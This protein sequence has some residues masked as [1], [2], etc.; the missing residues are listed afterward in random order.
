MDL[1]YSTTLAN[2]KTCDVAPSVGDLGITNSRLIAPGDAAR[3]V[4]IARMSRRDAHGMPPLGSA[5]VDAE[6]AALLTSWVN[7]LTNCN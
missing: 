2:T 3:S 1:R 5:Q 7:S 6:G 4:L